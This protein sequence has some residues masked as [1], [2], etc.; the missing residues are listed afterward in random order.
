MIAGDATVA[1]PF[2][3]NGDVTRF[4]HI[5]LGH[6]RENGIIKVSRRALLDGQ[7]ID[8]LKFREQYVFRK[9][10]RVKF[11]KGIRNTKGTLNYMHFDLWRPTRVP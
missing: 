3:S 8:K 1:T 5:H 6:M 10:K 7:S 2:L 11:T 4:W 9:E